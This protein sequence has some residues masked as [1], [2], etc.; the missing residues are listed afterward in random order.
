MESNKRR[1]IEHSHPEENK[2][3]EDPPL[4]LVATTDPAFEKIGPLVTANNVLQKY[5]KL[6]VD[7]IYGKDN[8]HHTN[9]LPGPLP[10]G[11]HARH[12]K[13]MREN[14]DGY[15]ATCKMDGLRYMMLITSRG[16]YIANRKFTLRRV[17]DSYYKDKFGQ[18][19]DTLLDGELVWNQYGEM[20][21]MVFD[22]CAINSE[23]IVGDPLSVRLKA[24]CHLTSEAAKNPMERDRTNIPMF[25]K[26]MVRLTDL[27]SGLLDFMI[28]Y[29]VGHGYTYT[30]PY[31][32]KVL[33][34][35]L[36]FMTEGPGYLFQEKESLLKWKPDNTIDVM[37]RVPESPE[38]DISLY[39]FD[40]TNKEE[41]ELGNGAVEPTL[42]DRIISQSAG[43]KAVC[44]ECAWDKKEKVWRIERARLDKKKPN[45]FFTIEDTMDCIN[46]D[47]T[48]EKLVAGLVPRPPEKEG[49][50]GE[51]AIKKK[52]VPSVSSQSRPPPPAKTGGPSK[53]AVSVCF[54]L[55][56]FSFFLSWCA[57]Y[58]LLCTVCLPRS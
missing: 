44:V 2:V 17:L 50:A 13:A 11:Y 29:P 22:C 49:E 33:S 54:F 56:F 9:V 4:D 12:M 40:K 48:H 42:W 14:L 7:L 35:G 43:A 51:K 41:I 58:F 36:V 30:D 23:I 55:S 26:V 32:F 47:L 31:G 38:D 39:H 16:T 20:R 27:K 3:R 24:V 52:A 5:Q 6:I 18:Y 37:A 45:H 25:N 15:F 19:G 10:A 28:P 46:E 53:S 1:K 34:D 57:F 8:T 21:Y